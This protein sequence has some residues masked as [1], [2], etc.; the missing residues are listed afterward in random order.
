[1]IITIFGATGMVGRK[2]VQYAL[3]EGHTVRAFGRNIHAAIFNENE[4]LDLISGAVF[5]DQQVFRAVN[6]S[7]AVFSVLGGSI[8][9]TDKSRS[10]GMKNIV[11]QMEKT[12]VKRIITLGGKGILDSG[13]GEMLMEDPAYP[14]QYIAVGVEHFKA[15]EFLKASN[16]NWTV[17]AAPD[18]KDADATGVYHSGVDTLPSVDNNTITTGDLAMFFLKEVKKNE[19]IGQRVGISN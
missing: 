5:D 11:T 4:K 2:L 7:D 6:G 9:G 3:H 10:L 1:M 8:D 14:R 16:L 13:N 15:Y 18:I 17:V 19:H 12:G